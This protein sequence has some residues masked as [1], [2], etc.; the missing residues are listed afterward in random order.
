MPHIEKY[1]NALSWKEG[2][3]EE[4][5]TKEQMLENEARNLRKEVDLETCEQVSSSYQRQ[6]G[7]AAS[8]ST[9]HQQAAMKTQQASSKDKGKHVQEEQL[10][11][12]TQEQTNKE[13]EQ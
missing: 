7:E 9:T 1:A 11:P 3:I 2:T 13:M 8:S 6:L 12:M 4:P 10:P 5:I